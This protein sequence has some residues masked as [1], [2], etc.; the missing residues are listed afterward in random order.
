MC[1]EKDACQ[2][3]SQ[4]FIKI[5]KLLFFHCLF[6]A[7][8]LR[9]TIYRIIIRMQY[10]DSYSCNRCNQKFCFIANVIV[11]KYN[12]SL[13]LNFDIIEHGIWF[14][15][16]QTGFLHFVNCSYNPVF[17]HQCIQC[18]QHLEYQKFS[19]C[20]LRIRHFIATASKCGKSEIHSTNSKCFSHLFY[21]Q[22]L[23]PFP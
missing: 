19:H 17:I 9:N 22:N 12:S 21:P 14:L 15:Q 7:S 11:G 6:I 5:K 1:H 13:L 4:C 2:C 18:I 8:F 20:P 16:Y 23:F 3:I 10:V